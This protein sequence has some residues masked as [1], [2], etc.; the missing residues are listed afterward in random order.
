MNWKALLTLSKK[1]QVNKFFSP[2]LI[3]TVDSKIMENYFGTLLEISSESGWVSNVT[4]E[5][6]T[7]KCKIHLHNKAFFKNINEF[8]VK[9]QWLDGFYSTTF[10]NGNNYQDCC[11]VTK[12]V[13]ILSHGNG[14]VKSRF[15]TDED[16]FNKYM[17]QESIVTWF[18][19]W[20]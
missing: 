3:G 14:W 12:K 11:L 10:L 9:S 4:A 19:W 20:T 1:I 13:L 8:N 17:K 7:E 16:L 6:A 2:I 18:V 15:S 5:R